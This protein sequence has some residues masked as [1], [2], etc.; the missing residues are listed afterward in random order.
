VILRARSHHQSGYTL[1]E[2]ILVCGV[3]ALVVAVAAPTYSVTTDGLRV[4]D[5][6]AVLAADIRL[7]QA[8]AQREGRR[9]RLSLDLPN[10]SYDLQ[11]ATLQ[12]AGDTCSSS[13]YQTFRRVSLGVQ[14]QTVLTG[15]TFSC[16]IFEPTGRTSGP[17]PIVLKAQTTVADAGNTSWTRYLNGAV[18]AW[19]QGA[20]DDPQTNTW[21]GQQE[22]TVSL[23]LGA[24]RSVDGMCPEVIE[25]LVNNPVN[26]PASVR[27]DWSTVSGSTPPTASQWQSSATFAVPYQSVT[28]SPSGLDWRR[29]CP[30]F[31][32]DQPVRYV[33]FVFAPAA[34]LNGDLVMALD[35]IRIAAPSVTVQSQSGRRSRTITITPITGRVS[36]Q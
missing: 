1:L 20:T 29:A 19:D 2:V 36:V 15:A 16:L 8:Q 7:V 27:L 25:D 17:S 30:A 13:D 11:V 28:R 12:T 26:F 21:S 31:H 24:V 6:A 14:F 10:S 34:N 33:R 18:T 32:L 5:A 22:V 3:I 23:D 9:A 35:E 4:R